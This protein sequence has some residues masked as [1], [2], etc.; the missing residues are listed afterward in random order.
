MC[1]Y[2]KIEVLCKIEVL[3]SVRCSKIK[4][5]SHLLNMVK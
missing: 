1:G 3:L 4:V 5:I 2:N